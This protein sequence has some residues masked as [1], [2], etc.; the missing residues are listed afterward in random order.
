[1]RV[2]RSAAAVAGTTGALVAA[3]VGLGALPAQAYDAPYD[4]TDPAGYVNGVRCADTGSAK[5]T[6]AMTSPGGVRG[7]MY[8]YYSSACRTTWAKV[9]TDSPP[10]QPGVDYCGSATVHRNSDGKE[11]TCHIPSG[12]SSCYTKQVNDAN[13]TSYAYGHFD[14]GPWTYYGTTGSY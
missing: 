9:V 6:A 8:L 3:Q 11:M 12:Q 13:V 4:G 5:R 10:C 14:N 2:R 1:M 7:T